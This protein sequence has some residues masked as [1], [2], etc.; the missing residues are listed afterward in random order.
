MKTKKLKKTVEKF[1][2]ITFSMFLLAGS[3]CLFAQNQITDMQISNAVDKQ[4]MI[5]ATTP[6]HMIDVV[7]ES[8]IVTLNGEVNSLLAKENAIK[9]AQMVKGV[10]GVIDKI[11]VATTYVSDNVL[12]SNVKDALFNDPATTSYEITVSADNGVVTLDGEVDSWQ[13]KQLA[14]YVTKGVAGVKEIKNNLEIDFKTD[15]PDAEIAQEIRQALKFNVS[16]DHVLIDVDVQQGKVTLS[17]TVGSASEKNQTI[18]DAWVSGVNA[19]ESDNLKVKEWARS[20]DLRK[21]KYVE[22]TD[23]EIKEAINDAFLYDPRVLHFNPEVSVNNGFVTLSGVVTNLQAKYAAENTARNIVGVFG[24]NN[25]LKVRPETTPEDSVL[26]ENLNEAIEQSPILENQQVNV[27]AVNGIVYLTGV[28]NS[29]FEKLMAETTASRTQGVVAVNNYLDVL[30]GEE[31]VSYIY[32]D[33]DTYFPPLYDINPLRATS[34]KEIKRRI[35]NQ[36]WWSPYVNLDDIDVTV[37]G[38]KAILEGTVETPRESRFAV[39]NAIEGGAKKVENNL[40]V[41]YTAP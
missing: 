4:L 35:E 36:L 29:N 7:C 12:E 13:E 34:D 33:W 6:S 21:D 37:E 23:Q 27:N 19:V 1:V 20:D 2:L 9:V 11:E 40:I 25:N 10:R 15:R 22:K 8:G 30:G 17:G 14:S 38:G 28:V 16:I 18:A 5:N 26:E 24:V 31:Y 3:S 39:I 32:Y 41:T